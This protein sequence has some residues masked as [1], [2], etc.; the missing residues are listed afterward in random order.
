MELA[1]NYATPFSELG[2]NRNRLV[3]FLFRPTASYSAGRTAPSLQRSAILKG[4]PM[5]RTQILAKAILLAMVV[6]S[7]VVVLPVAAHDDHEGHEDKDKNK[8]SQPFLTSSIA[9]PRGSTNFPLTLT[10]TDL[11]GVTRLTGLGGGVS[12]VAGSLTSNAT[13][14]TVLLNI[15]NTA[16]LGVSNIGVTTSSGTSNTEAFRVVG[17]TVEVA[18]PTPAL[19][20]SSGKRNPKNGTFTISNTARGAN[21]GPLTLTAAPTIVKTAGLGAFSI[22]GGTC[23]SGMAID[24]GSNC[25]VTVQYVASGTSTSTA[26]LTI[27]DTGAATTSQSTPNF[28]AN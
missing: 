2:A 5:K 6:A 9:V 27:T 21:A 10:G 15:A 20:T 26:H 3:R 22:T 25:T 14:V 28:N 11:S 4:Y 18:G 13:S 19:T 23:V 16:T 24:A 12:V 7:S 1:W 17:A 8:K